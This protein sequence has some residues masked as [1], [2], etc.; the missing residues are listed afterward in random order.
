[1]KFP[2]KGFWLVSTRWA[3]SRDPIIL[4]PKGLPK[5]H[6][7]QSQNSTHW[8]VPYSRLEHLD[9]NIFVEWN[10]FDHQ[11][12]GMVKFLLLAQ[13]NERAKRINLNEVEWSK[14]NQK[15]YWINWVFNLNST[16]I[17]P[18]NFLEHLSFSNLS[19]KITIP[20]SVV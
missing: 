16:K 8:S 6:V 2:K 11:I 1:M 4:K 18:T 10:I 19:A 3:E 15:F 12:H 17:H 20:S 14:I 9:G 13:N 7:L 5:F